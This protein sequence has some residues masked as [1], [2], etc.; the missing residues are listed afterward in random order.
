MYFEI[1]KRD[2]EEAKNTNEIW[3]HPIVQKIYQIVGSVLGC[4]SIVD[5][6]SLG[7]SDALTKDLRKK[8][9]IVIEELIKSNSITEKDIDDLDFLVEFSRLL[10]AVKR[11]RGNTK[12]KCMT[13]IFKG[14]VCN[15]KKEY[16]LYEE[17]LQRI[18]DMSEREIDIL[19]IMNY[20]EEREAENTY[21]DDTR[22]ARL[23][24]IWH[25]EKVMIKNQINIDE[26]TLRSIIS[27]MQRTGFCTVEYIHYAGGDV[28]IYLLTKYFK[29]FVK[30]IKN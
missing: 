2:L 19:F 23:E 29:D 11:T 5:L 24:R 28:P 9:E 17:Y 30:F 21:K 12:I 1:K 4:S 26:S 14:T 22:E 10:E 6:F 13:D 20:C 7:L 3:N 16:D 27:G 15:G 8:Q 18:F 25:E